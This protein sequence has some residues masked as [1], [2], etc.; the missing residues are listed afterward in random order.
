MFFYESSAYEKW[1][2]KVYG[3]AL[4]QSGMLT[5]KELQLM[6]KYI[7][8]NPNSLILD[9]GCGL[10]GITNEIAENYLSKVIGI[11]IDENMINYAKKSIIIERIWN[12]I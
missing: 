6:F 7:K 9:V 3:K 10:G 5:Y 12:S 4:N 11:D 2:E 8:L 1:C